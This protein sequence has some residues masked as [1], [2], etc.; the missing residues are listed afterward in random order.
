MIE[1]SWQAVRALDVT[2][3]GPAQVTA[4]LGAIRRLEGFLAARSVALARRAA[5]LSPIPERVVATA[6]GTTDR[7]AMAVLDRVGIVDQVPVLAAALTAGTIGAGHVDGFGQ[8]L[9]SMEPAKRAVL[10]DAAPD[11]LERAGRGSSEEFGRAVRATGTDGTD[12]NGTDAIGTDAIG[13][14][15]HTTPPPRTVVVA[16]PRHWQTP[17]TTAAAAAEP[18]RPPIGRRHASANVN[19]SPLGLVR[20]REPVARATVPASRL[21]LS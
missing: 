13:T 7:N 15:T 5:E 11:L 12:A 21:D 14:T 6:S 9:R 19:P 1:Q 3:A 2:S 4:A 18:T 10:V 17:T 20:N 8:A 16:T